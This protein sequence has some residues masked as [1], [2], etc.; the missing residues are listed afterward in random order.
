MAP[1]VSEARVRSQTDRLESITDPKIRQQVA[2]LPPP[3]P[4]LSLRPSASF[5]R[6]QLPMVNTKRNTA[7]KST[8][9]LAPNIKLAPVPGN[10]LLGPASQSP[11]QSLDLGTG[12]TPPASALNAPP[13]TVIDV[14]MEEG[15]EEEGGKDTDHVSSVIF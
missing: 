9:G 4:P 3:A 7:R 2:F 12:A 6:P 5:A 14:D 8:G 1:G 11:S 10:R 13:P 15:N